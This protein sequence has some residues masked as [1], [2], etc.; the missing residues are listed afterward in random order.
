MVGEVLPMIEIEISRKLDIRGAGIQCLIKSNCT[1]AAVSDYRVKGM[2]DPG[3]SSMPA[4]EDHDD[5]D[6]VLEE[7]LKDLRAEDEIE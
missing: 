3:E 2:G 5:E 4:C 7:Y 1:N 6:L